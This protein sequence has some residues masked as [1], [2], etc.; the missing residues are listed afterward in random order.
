M[1]SRCL[2]SISVMAL[3]IGLAVVLMAPSPIAGQAQ[4]SQAKAAAP[5]AAAKPWT[6]KTPDGYPDLQGYWTNNSYTPLTRPAGVT[7]E[8]YTPDELKES[9]KRA[10][11][12]EAGR[13]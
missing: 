3:A 4:N 13:A 8:F 1:N 11:E 5:A 2:A 9:N 7:K 6:S 10:A 12:R